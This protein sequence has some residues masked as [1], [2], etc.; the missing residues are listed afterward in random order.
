VNCLY[1][2]FAVALVCGYAVCASGQAVDRTF[3]VQY[4]AG[5]EMG[6]RPSLAQTQLVSQ[7]AAPDTEGLLTAAERARLFRAVHR[8]S[9]KAIA[10]P[11]VKVTAKPVAKT[12]AANRPVKRKSRR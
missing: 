1:A 6:I 10:K 4:R 7:Q 2:A 12:R 8:G 11:T 5:A 9:F 3:P